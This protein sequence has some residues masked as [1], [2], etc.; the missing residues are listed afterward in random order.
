MPV[1]VA[2]SLLSTTQPRDIGSSHATTVAPSM[3]SN[4]LPYT[5][6]LQSDVEPQGGHGGGNI[7]AAASVSRL[8]PVPSGDIHYVVVNGILCGYFDGAVYYSL[9]QHYN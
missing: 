1:Q 9:M 7:I 4:P 2:Q 3:A 5:S 6:S 8:T